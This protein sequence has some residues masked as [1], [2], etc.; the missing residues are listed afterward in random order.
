MRNLDNKLTTHTL[1]ENIHRT[2]TAK[3]KRLEYVKNAYNSTIKV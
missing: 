1:E 2:Y 3:N